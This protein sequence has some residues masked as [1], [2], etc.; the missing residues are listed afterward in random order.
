MECDLSADLLSLESACI[1]VIVKSFSILASINPQD[2]IKESVN[3]SKLSS[4]DG[5]FKFRA[6]WSI[7]RR[8]FQLFSCRG[9]QIY[10]SLFLLSS[11][12]GAK[13]GFKKYTYLF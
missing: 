2:R 7:N 12:S 4:F 5:N 8:L 3:S 9:S 13:I 10:F 6:N 1:G 11:I